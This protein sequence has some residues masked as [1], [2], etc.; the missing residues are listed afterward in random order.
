MND[1]QFSLSWFPSAKILEG[2]ECFEAVHPYYND[3][4]GELCYVVSYDTYAEWTAQFEGDI[5]YKGPSLM[6]SLL[7]CEL[8]AN[9]SQKSDYSI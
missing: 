8:D 5:L 1:S 6:S 4:G 9:E 3:D 7:S 2:E